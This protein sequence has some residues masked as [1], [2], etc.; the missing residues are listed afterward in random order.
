MPVRILRATIL[1][2]IR[3]NATQHKSDY[4]VVN[5][6]LLVRLVAALCGAGALLFY[7]PILRTFLFIA[8][9]WLQQESYPF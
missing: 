5:N 2:P 6:A 7:G 3:V 8:A 4:R 1:I 9:I